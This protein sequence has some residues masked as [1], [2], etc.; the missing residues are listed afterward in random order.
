MAHHTSLSVLW[1]DILHLPLHLWNLVL[2]LHISLSHLT[3]TLPSSFWVRC[4][5]HAGT[6]TLY[7]R[8]AHLCHFHLRATVVGSWALSGTLSMGLYGTP[9][10]SMA[11]SLK[12]S[13]TSHSLFL[14]EFLFAL[15]LC[16]H[17]LSPLH[18]LSFIPFRFS[19]SGL[20]AYLS[21]LF[22]SLSLH[23][24]SHFYLGFLSWEHWFLWTLYKLHFTL[25]F[26]TRALVFTPRIRTISNRALSPLRALFTQGLTRHTQTLFS[27]WWKVLPALSVSLAHAFPRILS[28]LA[29][30][31]FAHSFALPL[32]SSLSPSPLSSP[33]TFADL[34]PLFS[35]STFLL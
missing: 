33:L 6:R 10:L 7:H 17:S 19:L 21:R 16:T 22:L 13:G 28:Q 31:V 29:S 20:H 8:H 3:C 4:S 30:F 11:D 34:F 14:S 27:L 5:T 32:S 2:S 9:A 23:C 24:L 18:C 25:S 15:S 12:V 35:L 26:C 1:L